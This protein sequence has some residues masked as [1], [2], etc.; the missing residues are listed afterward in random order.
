M[1]RSMAVVVTVTAA[2]TVRVTA[3]VQGE[4]GLSNRARGKAT[5][6]IAGVGKVGV[7]E[8]RTHLKEVVAAA[9]AAG[10]ESKSL[11]VWRCLSIDSTSPPSDDDVSRAD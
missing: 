5:G 8:R 3:N 2:T 9:A 6:V 7:K 10:T 4:G 1:E 11:V